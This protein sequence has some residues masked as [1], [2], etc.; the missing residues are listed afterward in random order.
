MPLKPIRTQ[1]AQLCESLR[2]CVDD[3]RP[4]TNCTSAWFRN[5]KACE[6]LPL[7][8]I[9]RTTMAT[10]A[11][12]VFLFAAQQELNRNCLLI[13]RCWRGA[14]TCDPLPHISSKRAVRLRLMLS[15]FGGL[16]ARGLRIA[17][18]A[19]RHKR[20]IRV[21]CRSCSTLTTGRAPCSIQNP[22]CS[23]K[24]NIA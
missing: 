19:R 4:A 17:P 8:S 23:I 16:D 21:S 12:R 11:T 5:R 22:L 7:A 10:E 6:E 13:S 15:S 24:R 3:L 14:S 1:T 18:R 9:G 2:R 20:S